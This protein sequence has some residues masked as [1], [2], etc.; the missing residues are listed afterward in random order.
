MRQIPSLRPRESTGPSLY[1]P[2][3]PKSVYDDINDVESILADKAEDF[4]RER[5]TEAISEYLCGPRDSYSNGKLTRRMLDVIGRCET[6][7]N[8]AVEFRRLPPADLEDA[9]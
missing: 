8:E 9:A 4:I 6:I 1:A 2:D 7:I 3:E 5:A